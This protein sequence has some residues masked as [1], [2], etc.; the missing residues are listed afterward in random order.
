MAL[1]DEEIY[2]YYDRECR[3]DMNDMK[4]EKKE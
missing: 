2:G 4:G 3:K 1:L